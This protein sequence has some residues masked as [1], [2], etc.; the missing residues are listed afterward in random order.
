MIMKNIQV[1]ILFLIGTVLILTGV[2]L[3]REDA[4]IAN[5]FLIVGM[6]F[7]TVSILAMIVKMMTKKKGKKDSFLDS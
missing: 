7:E 2:Y 4:K 5:F 6:T 1:F 3:K